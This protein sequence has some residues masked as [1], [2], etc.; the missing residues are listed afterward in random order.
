MDGPLCLCLCWLGCGVMGHL[1]NITHEL[2]RLRRAREKPGPV[3]MAR[4]K[5]DSEAGKSE[6]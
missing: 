3:R 1:A 5:D 6:Y 4:H 2:Q